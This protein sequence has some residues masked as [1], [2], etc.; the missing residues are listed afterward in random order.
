MQKNGIQVTKAKSKKQKRDTQ[1]PKTLITLIR[2]RGLFQET[3]LTNSE[4]KPELR[5]D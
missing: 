1:D 5:V 4:Y 3:G 2:S